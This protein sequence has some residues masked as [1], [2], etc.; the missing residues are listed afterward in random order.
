MKQSTKNLF[1]YQHDTLGQG[2]AIPITGVAVKQGDVVWQLPCP[3]RHAN[4]LWLIYD[5]TGKVAEGYADAQG[6]VDAAG[7]YLSREEALVRARATDQLR[8]DREVIG[9]QL[10]SE[11]L[12]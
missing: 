10:Y 5:I 12:W 3:N 1:P 11:N 7:N 8:D 6:F 2:D 9:N 4:V